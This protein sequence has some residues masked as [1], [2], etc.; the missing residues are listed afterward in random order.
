MI[1]L[2]EGFDILYCSF[3][4]QHIENAGKRFNHYASIYFIQ[5]CKISDFNVCGNSDIS[6]MVMK[7]FF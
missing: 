5:G 3:I 7:I 1:Y 4:A 6:H 2:F